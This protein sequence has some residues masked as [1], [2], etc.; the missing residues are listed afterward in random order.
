MRPTISTVCGLGLGIGLLLSGCAKKEEEKIIITIQTEKVEEAQPAA[1]PSVA[2]PQ[3]ASPKSPPPRVAKAPQVDSPESRSATTAAAP[4]TPLK[5]KP[6]KTTEAFPGRFPATPSEVVSRVPM[7]PPPLLPPPARP[8]TEEERIMTILWR[9]EAAFEEKNMA[10]YTA[11]MITA[12]SKLKKAVERF[13]EQYDEIEVDFETKEIT[14]SG[15]SAQVVLLQTTH[16]VPKRGGKPQN[17]RAKILWGLR[18]V[19]G[20]WKIAE[21]KILEKY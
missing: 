17:T 20:D 16:L 14:V 18:K 11:D 2:Q 6:E 12:T 1:P 19:E 5:D 15:E 10:L 21:T 13:F 8:P 7:A 3:E 4:A 9:Q